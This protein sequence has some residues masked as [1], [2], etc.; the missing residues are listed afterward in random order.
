MNTVKKIDI[1]V[2]TTESEWLTRLPNGRYATPEELIE[3]YDKIGV[4]KGVLLP[5]IQVEVGFHISSNFETKNIADQYPDRFAWFCNLDARQGNNAP[6]TDFTPY[7]QFCKEKG[8]KG[9]GEVC[10]NIYF[11]DP[12]MF[13]MLHHCEKNDMPLIFHI[14]KMGGDYGIVDD[15]GLP[16]LEKAL[17]MFP[18]LLFLGHSQMFWC[19][20]N[21]QS[22]D[23]SGSR[24]VELMRKYPNLCGDLSANSGYTAVSRDPE[25]G[26]S[27]LEEFQDR[28]YYGTDICDPNQIHHPMLKLATFLDEGML[29]GQ[30]SCEAYYKISRGNAEK[31]LAK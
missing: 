13:N 11:D 28:L 20:I 25:F 14:G 23:S 21:G 16:R 18:K 6:D 2:H 3:I 31:L 12:R 9:I 7:I 29:S 17:Q 26:Y 5:N 22:N 24:L 8:A 30:L 10:S 27:F 1:H 4:E 19:E 15:P